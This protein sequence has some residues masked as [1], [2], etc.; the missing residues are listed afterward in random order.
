MFEIAA[1]A[2][3]GGGVYPESYAC[4]RRELFACVIEVFRHLGKIFGNLRLAKE[5]IAS[6]RPDALILIDYTGG[7][8]IL[9]FK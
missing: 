4:Y 8:K 7:Y 1:S 2:A 3:V 6:E 9:Q 5:A